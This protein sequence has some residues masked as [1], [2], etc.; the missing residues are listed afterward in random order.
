MLILTNFQ[1]GITIKKWQQSHTTSRLI[2]IIET[3]PIHYAKGER[4]VV[5]LGHNWQLHFS[6]IPVALNPTHVSNKVTRRS[7]LA[8]LAPEPTHVK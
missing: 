5:D 8:T 6:A 3:W 1:I 4:L 2:V 7:F